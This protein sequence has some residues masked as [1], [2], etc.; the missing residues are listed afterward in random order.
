M[1]DV[2]ESYEPR[3]RAVLQ[4]FNECDFAAGQSQVKDLGTC[5][6]RRRETLV[7][8]DE[9]GLA[10]AFILDTFLDLLAAYGG[11]WE[12]VLA[13]R[14]SASW[15]RLQDALDLL[16]LIKRLS[17]LDAPFF[18]NQLLALEKAYPYSLFASVGMTVSWFRCSLCGED[19]DSSDCPH[20][21]G[22]LYAGKMAQAIAQDIAEL[23]EIS[24]VTNPEDKR[25]VIS[26]EDTSEHFGLVAYI[27]DGVKSQ[28]VRIS[29]IMDV[30]FVKRLVPV[31]EID[32]APDARCP[33]GSGVAFGSCCAPKD[34]VE[35]DHVEIIV[36][37]ILI[38]GAAD[39]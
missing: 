1:A 18:E 4:A 8:D 39:A 3:F 20:V 35:T 26:H 5:F 29:D 38:Q 30:R 12:A 9:E 37:E 19:I 22:Q 25:C 13:A 15:V 33:C 24:L 17:G 14:F 21:R 32:A 6:A 36:E 11:F 16:R 23:G 10:D 27:A 28:A 31:P 7:P 34:V 2:L